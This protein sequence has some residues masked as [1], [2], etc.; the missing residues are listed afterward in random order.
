[1]APVKRVALTGTSLQ[2]SVQLVIF[3]ISVRS[4]SR[5]DERCR[6]R[7]TNQTSSRW[8]VRS[9]LAVVPGHAVA[10]G[11]RDCWRVGIYGGGTRETVSTRNT[12][13]SRERTRH[14]RKGRD[15][16]A[17]RRNVTSRRLEARETDYGRGMRCPRA[18]AHRDPRA[19]TVRL[20]SSSAP[21]SIPRLKYSRALSTP[22]GP[23]SNASRRRV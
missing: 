2:L 4:T 1:M 3:P 17:K 6:E 7:R 19:I 18:L 16:P 22:L 11:S 14:P 5:G 15:K 8:R 21:R 10:C 9:R 20:S 12:K 13:H 23:F